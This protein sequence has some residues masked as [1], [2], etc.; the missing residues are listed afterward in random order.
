MKAETAAKGIMKTGD[1]PDAKS[2]RVQCTCTSADH[3]VDAWI[4]VKRDFEDANIADIE[5][6]FY[7]NS[8]TPYFQNFWERLKTVA[9]VLFRG[10]SK[11][12]HCILLD[13]QSALNL[14]YAIKQTVESL[15]KETK[16]NA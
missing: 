16:K 9:E 1:W 7:V 2:Y 3:D 14:T 4:E 10:V 8:C 11:R 15:E 6:V 13:R 12:Q 5:V